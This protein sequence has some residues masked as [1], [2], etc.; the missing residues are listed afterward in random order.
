METQKLIQCKYQI[1]INNKLSH[2]NLSI[3][4]TLLQ[5]NLLDINLNIELLNKYS[6]L[7]FD[8]E[9]ITIEVRKIK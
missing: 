1:F 9:H 4:E 7:R 6:I 5:L 2:N 3:L 8:N